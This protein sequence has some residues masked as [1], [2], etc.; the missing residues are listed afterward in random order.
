MPVIRVDDKIALPAYKRDSLLKK[1]KDEIEGRGTKDGPVI[2]EIPLE[3]PEGEGHEIIDVLVV[4]EEWR[5]V[6]SEDR[7][8]LI[9][10]AY[11]DKREKIAQPLGVIYEEVV[12]QQLLPYTIVSMF[13]EDKKFLS[14]VCQSPTEKPDEI[15]RTICEAKRSVG[16]IEIPNGKLEL[17]FPTGAMA[18][19]I[20]KAL[21]RNEKYRD[22]YWRILPGNTSSGS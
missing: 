2:F 13:E 20:Y 8:S 22:L 14:L 16:G 17:R 7:S 18:E 1:L 3:R 6:P 15:L 5:G 12:Q 4:W 21:L 10:E 19:S 9:L 11:G